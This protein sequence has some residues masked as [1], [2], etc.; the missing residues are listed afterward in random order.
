M[1]HTIITPTEIEHPLYDSP[2]EFMPWSL[3]QG[4][5]EAD[6]QIGAAQQAHAADTLIEGLFVG[7]SFLRVSL[8]VSP[9]VSPACG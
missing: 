3:E 8:S 5:G 1:P 9:V 2:M 4:V 7:C 6:R